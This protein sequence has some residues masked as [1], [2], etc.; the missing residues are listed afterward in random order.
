MIL[1][2]LFA[3][4][5]R[6]VGGK[7]CG[8]HHWW[9]GGYSPIGPGEIEAVR[10]YGWNNPFLLVVASGRQY[11]VHPV[12]KDFYEIID[13]IEKHT[14]F[15]VTHRPVHKMNALWFYPWGRRKDKK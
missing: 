15:A 9:G 4:K 8:S 14:D 6:M 10:E 1:L 11:V 5:L 13:F 12:R 7:L 2:G 3:R